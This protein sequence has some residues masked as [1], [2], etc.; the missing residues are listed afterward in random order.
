[1]TSLS[2]AALFFEVISQDSLTKSLERSHTG[3]RFGA[4][5]VAGS[6]SNAAG[7]LLCSGPT[8]Y[9]LCRGTPF[10]RTGCAFGA[11]VDPTRVS[12]LR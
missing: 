5:A 10:V 8:D 11:G 1:M 6:H 4:M 9:A 3:L 2:W 12:R 7:M